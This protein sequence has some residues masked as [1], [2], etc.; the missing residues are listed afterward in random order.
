MVVHAASGELQWESAVDG[1]RGS[2]VA[3]SPGT[4]RFV[5]SVE[6]HTRHWTLWDTASGAVHMEGATE[7]EHADGTGACLCEVDNLGHRLQHEGCPVVAHTAGLSAV[8]FSPCGA[9]L[10]TGGSEHA[11]IVWDA[12]TGEAERRMEGNPLG[13]SSLSFSADGGPILGP[14]GSF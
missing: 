14:L 11:V 2:I 1:R 12:D 5:A 13:T 10:A 3:I 4:G 6:R 7:Q 9:K 8:V